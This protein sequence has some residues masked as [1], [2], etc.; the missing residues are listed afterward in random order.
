MLVSG[1]PSSFWVGAVHVRSAKPVTGVGEAGTGTGAGDGVGI[2]GDPPVEPPEPPP[3]PASNA[4][5]TPARISFC[6][7][8]AT[9]RNVTSDGRPIGP[10]MNTGPG[11]RWTVRIAAGARGSREELRRRSG[12]PAIRGARIARTGGF[13]SPPFNGYASYERARVFDITAASN[14][15][16]PS[17]YEIVHDR[18]DKLPG[19]DKAGR[20][21]V[22]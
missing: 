12:N 6:L 13:A 15:V 18:P 9:F 3:H 7:R 4:M 19:L 5:T 2:E 8:P 10:R 14:D 11:F 16:R 17:R 21:G 22:V 20:V 1:D